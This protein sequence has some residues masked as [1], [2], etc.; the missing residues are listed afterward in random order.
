MHEIF[1]F[2]YFYWRQ[3]SVATYFLFPGLVDWSACWWGCMQPGGKSSVA[4]WGSS[5]LRVRNGGGEACGMF[6]INENKKISYSTHSTT[7]KASLISSFK[8]SFTFR[9]YYRQD[10]TPFVTWSLH[11]KDCWLINNITQNETV[12]S[13]IRRV[14]LFICLSSGL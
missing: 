11:T 6:L 9:I 14:V 5:R 13:V 2:I 1:I 8:F 3:C 10:R 4:A 7:P 12:I